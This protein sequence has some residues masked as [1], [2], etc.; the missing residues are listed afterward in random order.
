[1]KKKKHRFKIR[2]MR[3]YVSYKPL[4]ILAIILFL[5]WLASG[6]FMHFYFEGE[7]GIAG[8]MFGAINSLFSGLAFSGIIYTVLI[9]RKE[10]RLQRNELSL[11]RQE[12][13]RSTEELA[14]QKE[15]MYLQRFETT[16]FNL[17]SAHKTIASSVGVGNSHGLVLFENYNKSIARQVHNG[18]TLGDVLPAY[19]R[20]VLNLELCYD[21]FMFILQFI[22]HEETLNT[23]K[24]TNYAEILVAQLPKSQINMMYFYLEYKRLN[25]NFDIEH[26]LTLMQSFGIHRSTSGGENR[27][28]NVIIPDATTA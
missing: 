3:V 21:N 24:K 10:L 11:Q 7:R 13:R 15:M 26:D 5:T 25:G 4:I 20:D 16:F 6:F 14:G 23:E 9:Q 18:E 19:L 27:D 12:V 1:M 2:L 17:I 28:R 22:S 8:D